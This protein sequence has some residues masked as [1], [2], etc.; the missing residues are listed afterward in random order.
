MPFTL[1]G[2]LGLRTLIDQFGKVG[3]LGRLISINRQSWS[4]KQR[5]QK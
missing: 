1:T 4:E 5:E 3:I 2:E